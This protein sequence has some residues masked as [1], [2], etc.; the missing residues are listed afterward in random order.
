M[1]LQLLSLLILNGAIFG[2]VPLPLPTPES[3]PVLRGQILEEKT[4]RPIPHVEVMIPEFSGVRT[5]TDLDGR[6]SIEGG[7]GWDFFGCI[8]LAPVMMGYLEKNVTVEFIHPEY[9]QL[10][11]QAVYFNTFLGWKFCGDSQKNLKGWQEQIQLK[12][13][14]IATAP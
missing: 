4:S 8:P 14:N 10:S 2:C 11:Q 7:R 13:K 9:Q 3:Y 1:K 12:P 5:S 6:F